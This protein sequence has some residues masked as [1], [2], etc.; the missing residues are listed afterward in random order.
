MYQEAFGNS[1]ALA[2]ELASNDRD[3]IYINYSK[4]GNTTQSAQDILAEISSRVLIYSMY[5][6]T[7][8][9]YIRQV[10]SISLQWYLVGVALR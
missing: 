3:H 2:I 6:F 10:L 4:L 9:C 7:R 8:I 1:L 5:F